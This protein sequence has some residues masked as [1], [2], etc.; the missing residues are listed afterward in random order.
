MAA[1]NPKCHRCNTCYAYAKRRWQ[2]C[3]ACGADDYKNAVAPTGDYLCGRCWPSQV[4]GHC[5]CADALRLMR[6]HGGDPNTSASRGGSASGGN[7]DGNGGAVNAFGAGVGKGV[8]VGGVGT[9]GGPHGNGGKTGCGN[10]A[11]GKGGNDG[12]SGGV[13]GQ[14]QEDG[15]KSGAAMQLLEHRVQ[16]L[17]ERL[18]L[19]ESRFP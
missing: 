11:P 8:A 7:N 5:R 12:S 6:E 14:G 17:E 1:A 16:L 10:A 18:R 2:A 19:L 9:E 3:D 15:R 4:R 13:R